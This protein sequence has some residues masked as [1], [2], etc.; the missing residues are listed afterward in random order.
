MDGRWRRR[1][2]QRRTVKRRRCLHATGLSLL[3]LLSGCGAEPFALA[4]TGPYLYPASV[5]P[6]L[7]RI[8]IV[9]TIT[10]QSR[11]DLIVSPTDF[12]SRD[13]ERRIYVANAAA[14]AADITQVSRAAELR[15]TLPLPAVTLRNGDVLTGYVVF[16]VPAGVRPVE[17]IW[18]QVDGDFTAKL[19]PAR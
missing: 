14:T 3:P 19:A 6:A 7:E 5:N 1:G 18:R 12:A 15:G 8:A 13:A 16:D 9:V 10:S 2:A 11:D 4:A 17:L